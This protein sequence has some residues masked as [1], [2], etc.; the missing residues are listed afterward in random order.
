MVGGKVVRGT[1][2]FEFL[3]EHPVLP[4]RTFKGCAAWGEPDGICLPFTGWPH[5]PADVPVAVVFRG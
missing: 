3:D 1:G 4:A 5:R 2:L